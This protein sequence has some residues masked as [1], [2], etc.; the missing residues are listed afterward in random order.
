MGGCHTVTGQAVP[1][2]LKNNF[3]PILRVKQSYGVDTYK[4]LIFPSLLEYFHWLQP[5]EIFYPNQRYP[6][7]VLTL[8]NWPHLLTPEQL[9]RSPP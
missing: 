3:P 5:V 6:I 1:N 7:P 9:E 8:K 2:V 4:L